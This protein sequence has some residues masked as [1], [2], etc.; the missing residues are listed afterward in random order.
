MITPYDHN[1]L[2]LKA[3]LFLHKAMEDE[4]VRPF[5]E[6]ALWAAL[7]LEL[8]AKSALAR[9][10]PLLIATPDTDGTNVLIALGLIGGTARFESVPAKAVFSRCEKAFKPFNKREAEKIAWARNEYLHS[11]SAEFTRIPESAWWPRF[12]AQAVVLISAC[13][14]EIEDLVGYSR[15][16]LVRG[17]LEQNKKNLEH[18]AE[19]LIERARQRRA[20][21]EAGTLQQRVANEWQPGRVLTAGLGHSE[22][23]DCPACGAMGYLEGEDVSGVD[24]EY[25]QIAEDDYDVIVTLTVDASYFSCEHCGLVL[26]DYSLL[27]PAGLEDTFYTPGDASDVAGY[28][29]EYGND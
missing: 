29:G 23:V 17:Y 4:E 11:A 15:T 22:P 18:R 14:K 12:W 13:D 16:D 28:E 5:D 10:S 21:Y 1:A 9:Q 3:K 27:E 24:T 25:Q 8:L 20:Q 19:M 6:R 2:W 7:A 26:D